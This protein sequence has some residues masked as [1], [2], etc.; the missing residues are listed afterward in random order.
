MHTERTGRAPHAQAPDRIAESDAALRGL[1]LRAGA[2]LALALL[3]GVAYA[4]LG[5]L[6]GEMAF[7]RFR[8]VRALAQ[9]A[10]QPGAGS[11]LD[12]AV[13]D[14]SGEAELVM[15]FGRGNP[16]ALHTV[17]AACLAWSGDS[18]LD[19]LLRLRLA[20][21]AVTAAALGVRAAPS[22]YEQWLALGRAHAALGMDAQ[23]QTCLARA[24]ELAPPGMVLRLWPR[25]A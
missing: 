15:L 9:M 8:R 13:Q 14:A 5:G 10:V 11:A 7:A 20:E 1:A 21:K 6:R 3:A 17:S 25:S 2:V 23:A 19:V 18:G 22:D 24:Q 16:D 12:T 4:E